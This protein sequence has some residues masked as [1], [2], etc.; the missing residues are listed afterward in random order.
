ML[1][2][3]RR[4]AKTRRSSPEQAV[5]QPPV[6]RQRRP[7]YSTDLEHYLTDMQRCVSKA[8]EAEDK[9]Y[10]IR[11]RHAQKGLEGYQLDRACEDDRTARGAIADNRWYIS[12]ATMYAVATQV[13]LL[14][15]QNLL[16]KEQTSKV[17]GMT[18]PTGPASSG[19]RPRPMET[20]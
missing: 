8:E 10:R 2:S 18:V 12:Q 14:K 5:V 20:Q 1:W 16:F 7:V 3:G 17:R 13:L 15:E 11:D 19:L 6:A 4:N 9:Y